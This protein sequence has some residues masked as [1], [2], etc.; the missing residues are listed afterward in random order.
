MPF[1]WLK[2]LAPEMNSVMHT[3][4]ETFPLSLFNES[5]SSNIIAMDF[6]TKQ[7]INKFTK[8]VVIDNQ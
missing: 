4:I 2:H 3:A 7:K 6:T 8:A 1:S 5:L